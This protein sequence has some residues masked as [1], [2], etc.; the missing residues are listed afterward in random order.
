MFSDI[1]AEHVQS[2]QDETSFITSDHNVPRLPSNSHMFQSHVNHQ[3]DSVNGQHRDVNAQLYSH[4]NTESVDSSEDNNPAM[5]VN[6]M[7]RQL[8]HI[9]DRHSDCVSDVGHIDGHDDKRHS[10]VNTQTV[11]IGSDGNMQSD[12]VTVIGPTGATGGQGGYDEETHD[13]VNG[14][15][16]SDSISSDA[17]DSVVETFDNLSVSSV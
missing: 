5:S 4:S 12:P 11:N 9:T 17:R 14:L 13:K 3:Q 6:S 2:A 1:V 10:F 8:E 16:S 7:E 15:L